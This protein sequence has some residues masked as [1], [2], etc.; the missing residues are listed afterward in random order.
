MRYRCLQALLTSHTVSERR[1]AVF[2]PPAT[3]T[4]QNQHPKARP[5]SKMPSQWI[6]LALSASSAIAFYQLWVLMWQNGTV[7]ALETAV[8][9]GQLADGT[10]LKTSYTGFRGIDHLLSTLVAFTYRITIGTKQP[11]WLLMV[12]LVSSLQ[13]AV[14]WCLVDS[15]RMGRS[16]IWLVM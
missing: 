3:T 13:T 16:P 8:N 11:Q 1:H 14:L 15:L 6:V 9:A 4:V 5:S 12:D 10:P 2:D 7:A